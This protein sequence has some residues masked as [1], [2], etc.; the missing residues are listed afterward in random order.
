VLTE[1]DRIKADLAVLLTSRD[2]T[3][4][5][6]VGLAYQF[7]NG[8]GGDRFAFSVVTIDAGENGITLA[9]EIGHNVGAGHDAATASGDG[10]DPLKPY[11]YGYRFRAG[12]EKRTY[13]DIMAY[14]PGATLPFFST[15]NFKWLGKPIG[16]ADSA[17]N[18]R[19]V[20]EIAPL[21]AGY[22]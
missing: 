13:K 17:D 12:A 9:H 6:V 7:A 18:A 14:G 20:K 21:V 3:E 16:N 11:A 5:E 1:R 4:G 22:R 2:R 10:D 19:I 8:P 15:P